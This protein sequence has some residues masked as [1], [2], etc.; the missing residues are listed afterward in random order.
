[1]KTY[2]FTR[3]TR[4]D[5]TLDDARAL[6]R[7]AMTLR[8][9]FELECGT[10][11]TYS[12]GPGNNRVTYSIER[13]DVD[14]APYMYCRSGDR[15]TKWRTPDR[16]TGARERIATIMERYPDLHYYIQGD[17]RGAALY[18]YTADSLRRAH[19]RTGY[20]HIEDTMHAMYSSIGVAIHE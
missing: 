12:V 6:R 4:M 2:D 20:E 19:E 5:I 9:W 17:P 1:M 16:E 7:A 3:L 15:I 11:N 8:R 10:G 18:V 13:D 14:G